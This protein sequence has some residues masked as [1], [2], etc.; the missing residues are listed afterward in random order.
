[1]PYTNPNFRD[2]TTPAL[3]AENMN[4]LANA[5]AQLSTAN[6]GTGRTTLTSGAILYGDGTNA[7][8]L[9][10]GTGAVYATTSGS[11]Q[12]GTLPVT[13]GGTGVTSLSA[14]KTNLG[15]AN[16]GFVVQSSAPADTS[17][18]WINSSNSTMN[19]YDGSSWVAIR[20]VF[21]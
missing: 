21:A 9:L 17:V 8:G 2:N 15:L 14:L 20:G 6:G 7:V 16:A 19:Y 4:N 3:S 10:V 12:F 18:L 13:C 1:M 11:P 5:V